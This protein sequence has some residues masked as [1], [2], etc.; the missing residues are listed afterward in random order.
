[1]HIPNFTYRSGV[2][3][4]PNSADTIKDV[5]MLIET[6][7]VRQALSKVFAYEVVE[8]LMDMIKEGQEATSCL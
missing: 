6:G 1:M 8:V 3:E 4:M 7:R 5:A 2:L